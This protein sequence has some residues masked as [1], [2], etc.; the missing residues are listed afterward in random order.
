M[1]NTPEPRN[2]EYRET[3][4]M[5]LVAYAHMKGMRV[6]KAEQS[7]RGRAL[8]FNFVVHDPDD[9]WDEISTDFV[10]SESARYDSSVRILKRMC[11]SGR[12]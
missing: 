1:S 7:T 2:P 12:R 8:E 11:R 10:N 9:Q 4:N 3:G 6:V 5:A